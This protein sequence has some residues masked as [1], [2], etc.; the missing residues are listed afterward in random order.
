MNFDNQ[1]R[2]TTIVRRLDS[3]ITEVFDYFLFEYDYEG[4]TLYDSVEKS[5]W[6]DWK[7]GY[8]VWS[9]QF[10]FKKGSPPTLLPDEEFLAVP[11]N[12]ILYMKIEGDVLI[13]DS[14]V[15]SGKQIDTLANIKID[16]KNFDKEMII[17]SCEGLAEKLIATLKEHVVHWEKVYGI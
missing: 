1:K 12:A 9:I 6:Y 7:T 3:I 15:Y 8:T 4:L 17:K 13:I 11:E 5:A 16:M 14:L 2:I 10:S